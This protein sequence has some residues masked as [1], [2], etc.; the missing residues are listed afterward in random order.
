MGPRPQGAKGSRAAGPISYS[1]AFSLPPLSPLPLTGL[2][3]S[4]TCCS[5]VFR[6]YLS[7]L[8][9]ATQEMNDPGCGSEAHTKKLTSESLRSF[10]ENIYMLR[11]TD[12]VGM[13]GESGGSRV[14]K[15]STFLTSSIGH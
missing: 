5:D 4:T 10:K 7:T 1:H 8:P 6:Y 2:S 15:E 3:F 13:V 9:F 14:D 12:S 11:A